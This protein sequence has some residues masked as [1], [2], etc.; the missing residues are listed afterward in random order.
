MLWKF[1]ACPRC[2]EGDLFMDEDMRDR[3]TYWT[4]LQCGYHSESKK[5]QSKSLSQMFKEIEC[6]LASTI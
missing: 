3:E 1:K 2:G 5:S 6:E 4:C